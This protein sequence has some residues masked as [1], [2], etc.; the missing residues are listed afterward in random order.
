MAIAAFVIS[1]PA[2]VVAV[3]SLLNAR[4]E[5]LAAEQANFQGVVFLLAAHRWPDKMRFGPDWSR[6]FAWSAIALGAVVASMGFA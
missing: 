2:L 3:V 1:I 4:R 6:R 5:A